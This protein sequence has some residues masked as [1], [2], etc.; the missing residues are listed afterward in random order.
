MDL[1]NLP[2]VAFKPKKVANNK[3]KL[4]SIQN[5]IILLAILASVISIFI[6]NTFLIFAIVI[7]LLTII[8]VSKLFM[9]IEN[10]IIANRQNMHQIIAD[11]NNYSFQPYADLIG[12]DSLLANLHKTK[13]LQ[14]VLSGYIN[15][16]PFTKADF[17]HTF[18]TE[19]KKFEDTTIGTAII[20]YLK[21]PVPR[22]IA[23]ASYDP[24]RDEA[25]AIY[26]KSGLVL[27]GKFGGVYSLSVAKGYEKD[28]LYIFTPEL[29]ELLLKDIPI[30]DIELVDNTVII[31]L[32]KKKL[33]DKE[34]FIL[35][36]NI[37][38]K[39]GPE[40]IDN[41]KNYIDDRAVNRLQ[42]SKNILEGN[43]YQENFKIH[44]DGKKLKKYVQI[45][46]F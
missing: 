28:A 16:V 12:G 41:T 8:A 35:M 29:M 14:N 21:R 34:D 18:K 1:I 19:E 36:A 40:F 2:D 32:W 17:E 22:I 27:E 33:I 31:Y 38:A 30:T 3:T 26:D 5:I 6:Y 13:E 24:D 10:K 9:S 45:P 4:F 39:A 23:W 25:A 11:A 44:E 43:N 37:V 7:C 42:R 20:I 46:R 15:G